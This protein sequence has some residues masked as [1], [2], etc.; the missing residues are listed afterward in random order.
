MTAVL[1]QDQQEEREAADDNDSALGDNDSW[2][3]SVTS[4]ILDYVQLHGRTYHSRSFE[5]AQYW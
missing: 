2:T 3:D 5:G 1:L 4:S